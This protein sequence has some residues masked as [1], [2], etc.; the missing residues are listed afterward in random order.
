MADQHLVYESGNK[1]VIGVFKTV[2]EANT[3]W[4]AA[5]ERRTPRSPSGPVNTPLVDIGWYV[6]TGVS[7][8]TASAV[9][10]AAAQSTA[11]VKLWKADL[12]AAFRAY[13][14]GVAPGSRGA[15]WP[16]VAATT[17]TAESALKATDIWAYHQIALGSQIA[18]EAVLKTQPHHRR[19][20]LRPYPVHRG[21]PVRE[22]VHLVSGH[23]RQPDLPERLVSV[24]V[25]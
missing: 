9:F 16:S 13:A 8:S 4:P 18:D 5:R 11:R 7:P 17:A 3:F 25:R 21:F 10:P 20:P 12:A 24:L 6:D 19:R 1:R 15:W 2:A 14:S 23:A 22:G